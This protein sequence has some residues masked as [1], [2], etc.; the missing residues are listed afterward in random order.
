MLLGAGV[1]RVCRLAGGRAQI[2]LVAEE[3][4]RPVFAYYWLWL[5]NPCVKSSFGELY[6]N[7]GRDEVLGFAGVIVVRGCNTPDFGLVQAMGSV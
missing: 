6:Q 1:V 3:Q 7:M 2:N 4:V 5:A